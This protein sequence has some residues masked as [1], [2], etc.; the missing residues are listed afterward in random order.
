M[1]FIQRLNYVLF[2]TEIKQVTDS[3]PSWRE[4]KAVAPSTSF[5]KLVKYGWRRNELIYACVSKKCNTSSQT[6]LRV[7]NKRTDKELEDHR[8]RSLIQRPNP[9]MSEF[10]LWYSLFLYHDFAGIAYYEKVKSRAGQTV[11]LWPMRPDWVR[12]QEAKSGMVKIYEYGPPGIEPIPMKAEDVLVFPLFDPLNEYGGYPPVAVAS[13]TGDLDNAVTDYLRLLFQEGGVPPGILKTTKNINETIAQRAREIWKQYYGGYQK[14]TE[15]AVLGNDM[16]YEQTG[17]GVDKMGLELLDERAEV[18]ICMVLHVPPTVIHSAIGMK[19]ATL[20]NA[21]SFQRDW[22]TDDL[23]PMYK[24]LNDTLRNQL[25][26]EYGDDIYTE[27][28]FDEVPA[29]R[30]EKDEDRK[31][32]LEE[33]RGGAITRNQYN[34][35]VGLPDLGPRGEVYLMSAAM[36]EVP[37]GALIYTPPEEEENPPEEEE[38]PEEEETET[39]EEPKALTGP[40]S[41]KELAPDDDER[42]EM[43]DK[44]RDSMDEFFSSQLNRIKESVEEQYGDRSNGKH[45][46][47]RTEAKS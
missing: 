34:E 7:Y 41:L 15:P 30:R 45:E 20:N 14:W 35:R 6:T 19:R 4:G 43:E 46:H 38:N 2:G 26:P 33:F 3:V 22:W 29:I 11:Q 27:W 17:L 5:P 31:Q 42:R 18:R 28:D 24:N 40:D 21:E 47:P 25:L 37:A 44:I 9:R 1:N 8:L 16:S 12:P 39:E 23:I 36:I 10:D 32:A 13:R